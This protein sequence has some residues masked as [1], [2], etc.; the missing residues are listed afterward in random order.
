M[1]QNPISAFRYHFLQIVCFSGVLIHV[2][3]ISLDSFY[4]FF[5]S[6]SRTWIWDTVGLKLSGTGSHLEFQLPGLGGDKHTEISPVFHG[7]HRY[8]CVTQIPNRNGVKWY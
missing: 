8:K 5:T 2:D 1:I 4:P 6:Q 7:Y 3:A